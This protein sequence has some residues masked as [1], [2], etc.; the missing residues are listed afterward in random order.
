MFNPEVDPALLEQRGDKSNNAN[1]AGTP[2]RSG[3]NLAPLQFKK[4][5]SPERARIL[6]DELD[7]RRQEEREIESI[8]SPFL[9]GIAKAVT[10]VDFALKRVS[11][12]G[13]THP[14]KM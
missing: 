11:V 9:R 10:R 7:R 4:P 5:Y 3:D 1:T 14:E 6:A 12:E 2:E 8:E 13:W